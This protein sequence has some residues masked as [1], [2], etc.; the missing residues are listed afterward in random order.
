MLRLHRVA[1]VWEFTRMDSHDEK[2]IRLT[3]HE[4]NKGLDPGDL[5]R[6]KHRK[7]IGKELGDLGGKQFVVA[8]HRGD[9]HTLIRC[10]SE[11]SAQIG[12]LSTPRRGVNKF[13][14]ASQ[15]LKKMIRQVGHCA[16]SASDIPVPIPI[17]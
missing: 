5:A 15:Q 8:A 13:V 9:K 1:L 2:E 4:A 17:L 14:A 16:G 11:V 3:F 6:E 10:N 12:R 7:V